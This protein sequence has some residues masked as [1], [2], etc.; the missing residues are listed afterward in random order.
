MKM[1]MTLL[2]PADGKVNF[3]QIEGALLTA[4]NL[5]AILDLDDPTAV[6]SVTDYTG[7]FPELG[8]PLVHS[9]K[10]DQRYKSAF[11]AAK[12]ILQGGFPLQQRSTLFSG[13]DMLACQFSVIRSR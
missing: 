6:Q 9:S 8:P 3:Q 5:I 11:R 1:L 4:G 10:V 7:N 2:S 13:S 12:N